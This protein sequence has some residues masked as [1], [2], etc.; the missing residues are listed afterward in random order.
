MG[1]LVEPLGDCTRRKVTKRAANW[2]IKPSERNSLFM[3]VQL[4]PAFYI[5]Y[6]F[7]H[8]TECFLIN[9]LQLFTIVFHY[10]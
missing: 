10:K 6:Y 1:R 9:F 4:P 3:Q 5:F 8:N 7:P 2:E